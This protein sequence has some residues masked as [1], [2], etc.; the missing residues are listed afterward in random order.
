M[1]MDNGVHINPLLQQVYGERSGDGR[2]RGRS[3]RSETTGWP[4][5]CRVRGRRQGSLG[6]ETEVCVLT[7]HTRGRDV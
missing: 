6:Q 1:A 3:G 5:G 4:S 2:H 7:S